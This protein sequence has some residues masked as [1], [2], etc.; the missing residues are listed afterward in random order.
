MLESPYER[1]MAR[2]LRLRGIPFRQQVAVPASYK[3]EA[4]GNGYRVDFVVNDELVV[5]LKASTA[6]VLVHRAQ[7]RTYLRMLKLRQGLLLNFNMPRLVDG[8]VSVLL[9][10]R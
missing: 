9:P 5:E 3:G 7:L 8:L 2:E 6:L 4:L 10:E 1:A